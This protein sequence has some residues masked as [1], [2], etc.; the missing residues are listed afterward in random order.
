[1]RPDRV[2]V[3]VRTERAARAMREIY[4]PFVRTGH[5]IMLTDPESAEMI[6]YVSNA[7]LA[8]RISFMNE[9]AAICGA[10]GAD[11]E[12]VRV[13]VGADRRIGR[14]FLFPGL[15]YGGS[16]FPKDVRALAATADALG[17]EAPMCRAIDAVNVRQRRVFEAPIAEELGPDL[18]G[19]AVAL[20][21][22]AF[23]P[24]TDDVR[25]APALDIVRHLRARGAA[26]TAFDPVAA[27]T[28]QAEIGGEISFAANR[29]DALDGADALVICTE[30]NEFRSPDFAEMARRM[31]RPLVFDGRNLYD[32]EVMRDAGF[33]YHSVGR[34]AV[35]AEDKR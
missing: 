9:M 10:M 33:T 25:E 4:A 27:E 8:S 18:T 1:M 11:V 14:A 31:K 28:A 5:P 22:L 2:V 34:P 32:L 13:G 15:G 17:L 35:R 29:Y 21:G 6:K 23:K 24:R 3:G 7:L 16:C 30:W 20:W 19:R 26:V 12:M